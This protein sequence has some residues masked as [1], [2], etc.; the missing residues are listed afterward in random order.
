[1]K[2]TVIGP[3]A[4]LVVTIPAQ[5]ATLTS[6]DARHHIGETAT[7]CDTVAS[8]HYAP[9]SRG[10]P[11]FLNLGHPYPN[12]DFTVVIWGEDRGKFGEP[13]TLEG[14]RICVTGPIRS[15]RGGPEIIVRDPGQV[16]E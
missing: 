8:T 9:R 2:L 11:T 7:V 14:Q 12:P 5:A 4:V 13:E 3:L 15:Y 16:K 6:G 10:Q 1:M